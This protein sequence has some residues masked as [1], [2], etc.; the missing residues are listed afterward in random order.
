MRAIR[1]DKT[2]GPEVLALEDVPTPTPGAGEVLVRN[3]ACGVN[4][5]DTYQRSGLYP[6]ALPSGLGQ[7]AAGVVTALGEGVSDF[8]VGER[9]TF[10][11]VMGAYAEFSIVPA[12]RLLTLPEGVAD[13]I[14]ASSLLKGLTARSLLKVT[15]PVKPGDTILWHA[16]AG[17]VGQIATQWAAHLGARVI[18]VVGNDEK[19][20]LAKANGCAEVIVSSREDIAARVR[21]LTNGEGV[22][23]VYDSVGKDTFEASLNSLAPLGMF[24]SFGNASG[25]VAPFSP[26]LLSQKGSLFFTRPTLFTYVRTTPLLREAAADLFAVLASGAVKIAPPTRYKLADAAQAHADLEARKTTG[27]LV[28]AP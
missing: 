10:T 16:A 3:A 18:G 23:V 26:L 8:R 5:I 25:P 15:R 11:N 22:P 1:F 17:G 13:D 14:A 12:V 20:A 2:G 21:E 24:V 28:L 9:V 4:F 27:S 19:V 7:E 6:V